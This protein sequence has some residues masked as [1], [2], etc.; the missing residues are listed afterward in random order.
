MSQNAPF[1][2]V[3]INMSAALAIPAAIALAT[4]KW[5]PMYAASVLKAA[6]DFKPR[7]GFANASLRNRGRL[8]LDEEFAKVFELGE[9]FV[10]GDNE[11]VM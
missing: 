10:K 9:K 2:A 11:H 8:L 1:V 6:V 3:T 4:P 5:S 7:L